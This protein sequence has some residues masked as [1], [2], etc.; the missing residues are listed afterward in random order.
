M[1]KD[2]DF[3]EWALLAQASPEAF[4]QR[5]REAINAFLDASGGEQRRLGQSLQREI[6]YEIDRAG[7]PQQAMS[8]IS[9]MMWAQVAFL[10]EELEALSGYMRK[11]ESSASTGA[12]ALALALQTAPHSQ[13]TRGS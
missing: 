2:F 12:A 8:A 11:V 6:D 13:S 10:G 7:S 1:E 9:R 3:H 5:R 4:E